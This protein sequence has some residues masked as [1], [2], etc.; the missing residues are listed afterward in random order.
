[1]NV[2]CNGGL[3]SPN[4]INFV[5]SFGEQG[6]KVSVCEPDYGPVFASTID[7]IEGTC[8]NFQG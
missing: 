6:V 3:E 7:A 8:E 2:V 1:M 4:L 5:D